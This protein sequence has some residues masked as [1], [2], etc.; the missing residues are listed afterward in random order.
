MDLAA[1]PDPTFVT[2][3][4]WAESQREHLAELLVEQAHLERKAAAAAINLLFRVAPHGDDQRALSALA[5]EELLHFERTLRLLAQ[6]GIAFAPLPPSPYAEQLKARVAATMPDRLVDEL[7]VASLI[8]AR[9]HER[10]ALLAQA[11]A[12]SDPEVAHFY[13]ELCAA[14]ERHERLY[15]ELAERLSPRTTGARLAALRAHEA[16]VLRRLPWQPRLHSGLPEAMR[17]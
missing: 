8:E 4:A 17:G 12:A 16:Q 6:R 10:M 14:E 3:P 9:S 13:R 5:R 1:S 11:L 7:L 15:V 2:P